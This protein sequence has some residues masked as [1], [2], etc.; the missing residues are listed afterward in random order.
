VLRKYA[1]IRQNDG[2]DCGAAA[3]ATIALHY[4]IPVGLQQMRDLAGTDRVGTNLLGLVQ[5]AER[6]GFSA[7]AV[8][9]PYEGLPQVPLPAIAHVRT[10]EGL[11]HFVVLH[12]VGTV[13]VVLADPARGIR[14]L[15]RA[16]FCAIWTGYILVVLPEQGL[17][18]AATGKTPVTAWRRFLDLLG[19][20]TPILVEAFACAMLM[21]VLGVTTSYFIQHL[22]DSVL[23][24]NEGRLL[25]ALSIG[26]VLIVLFR[27]LFGLLRGYLMAHVGRKVDLALIAGYARHVL[28]LPLQFFEMRRVG[29]IL[30][31]VNDAQKVRE[32]VSGTTTTAMVDGTLVVLMLTVLWIYDVPLAMVATVFIPL[33]LA[34]VAVH[35][36]AVRRQSREAMEDAA[37]LSAHLVEDISG[38]ETIKAYGAERARA[39]EGEHRLVGFV[40]AVYSLDLLGLSMNT[41][42]TFVAA[43]AG[44]VILWY[45]GHR[46][47]SG[48]LTIGQLMFFFSLLGYM[49]EPLERLASV[50]LKIQ[51]ALVAVDRLSQVMDLELEP[52]GVPGRA[53][54][55]AVSDAIELRGVGFRYGCRANVLEG[56]D[57]RIPAGRTVAIVG[58]SGSGKSTLLKLLMGFY[59]P[60]D[61]QI[62]IDGVDLRDFELASLRARIGLVSQDPFIFSG[63]IHENI[64]LGRP[65]ATREEVIEGARAAGLGEFIAGLPQRYE[66]AIGERGANLSG[67]QR[68]RLA[69]ARALLR[70]PEVLIFDE[71]TS[72]LD[73]ATERAI[74]KNLKTALAGKT[75]VLVAHRLSTIKDADHIYV[76]HQGRVV[77]EGTHRQLLLRE[78]RYWDLCRAQTDEVE[79]PLH[80]QAAA[81]IGNGQIYTGEV[82][83]A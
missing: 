73:T 22:V 82:N 37:R 81:M 13:G 25:N 4:R 46:V 24:R 41:L 17:R 49:L 47:M 40:R 6:L 51:D 38:V 62:L 77:E 15:S 9:G 69:I 27:T 66:T 56:L 53:R 50:N 36:S 3:L 74:Q 75:V 72:H 19:S 26:M 64:A 33:L 14:K 59:Q 29:E 35:H 11:G 54:F 28:G 7:K 43:L 71:A 55:T 39:E 8:K 20:H 44:V 16:E 57:L 2:S 45:G 63:T 67:G 79:S 52:V 30:S 65:G 5:A 1:Y 61:G 76:L 68:Q 48:A 10:K 70:R 78:G 60:T 23:A 42:G 34:S 12:R 32:A 18:Q 31:R 58:E 21:T 83:H 80:H